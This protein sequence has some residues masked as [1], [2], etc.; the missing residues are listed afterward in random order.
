[1]HEA[2]IVSGLM[3]ILLDHAARHG[4]RRIAS[5]TVKVGRLRSVEPRALI[6]CFEVFAEDTIAEGAELLV[7]S[8]PIRGRCDD[9]GAEMEIAG[10]VFRCDRCQGGR[11][12]V[13]SGQ[14]L[15]IDSFEAT[16]ALS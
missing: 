16:D 5:V 11:I 7:E 6:G 13:T 3:R 1:M 2:S 15:Y 10:F 12:T 8:V 14:E 9:C 4:V